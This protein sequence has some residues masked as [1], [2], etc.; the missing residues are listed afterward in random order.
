MAFIDRLRALTRNQKILIGVG[1][2]VVVVLVAVVAA[3]GG[4]GGKDEA[5]TTTTST[6]EAT[7]TT[8]E[9]PIAPLTGVPAAD[10][11]K[12]TRP[13]L[14]VKVDNVP[15]A[16]GVQEGIDNADIVFVEEVENGA[17]RLAVV[18]QSKDDTVG[19]VR[20]ARTSDLEIAGNLNMPYFAYSGANGG[21]LRLVANGPM[22]D[23]GIDRGEA[24]SVYTRNQRGRGL[25]RFFFPTNE[26]YDAGREGAGTP[27]EQFTFRKAGESSPGEVAAGA[28]IS[29]AGLCGTTVS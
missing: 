13:A 23:M 8:T 19:P 11:S 29:Y 22:I 9:P 25:L 24:T 1:I 20:S 14:V 5:A 15:K 28:A 2:A 12:R 27:P 21:V 3:G 7:T 16:F 4:G 26:M 17:T 6:T 10:E 18:F